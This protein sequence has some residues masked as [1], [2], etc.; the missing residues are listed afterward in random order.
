MSKSQTYN[1]QENGVVL[2]FSFNED[3]KINDNKKIFIEL[4]EKAKEDLEKELK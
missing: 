3:D 2:S 4:M 1:Y